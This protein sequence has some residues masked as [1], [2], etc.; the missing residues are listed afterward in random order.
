M[1]RRRALG[2]LAALAVALVGLSVGGP[3][4]P[5][6][7]AV[8]GSPPVTGAD[9]A[10]VLQG[11]TVAFKPLSN[12]HDPDNDL[13]AVCRIGTES[14]KRVAVDFFGD[15]VDVF[16]KPNAR[17][18]TYTFT[19]YACDYSYL[20]PGTITVTVKELPRIPVHKIASRPGA[21][22][23]TN[24]TDIAMRFLYG[25]F[26]ADEPDGDLVIAAGASAVVKVHRT[27]IDWVATSRRGDV[28]LGT[29]HVTG[30]ELG[31]SAARHAAPVVVAHRLAD[32]WRSA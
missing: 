23:V 28:Y 11:N 25:S 13:L 6:A 32:L 1:S 20:V 3:V 8:T 15:E 21:L 16:A 5:A 19:Y 18:G 22:R 24:P 7:Q 9:T 12:D 2:V 10:T 26:K 17:P 14:Y 30:I 31:R 29:G 27:R 4:L